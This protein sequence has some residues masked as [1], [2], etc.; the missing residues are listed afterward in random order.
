MFICRHTF[1]RGRRRRVFNSGWEVPTTLDV[2]EVFRELSTRPEGLTSF[3]ATERLR[4]Y[5]YNIVEERRE[6]AILDLLKR[7]WSPAAWLLEASIAISFILG[8]FAEGLIILTLLFVNALVGFRHARRSRKAVELLKSMLRP[9]ARVLRDGSWKIIDSREIVPGDVIL[10]NIGDTVPADAVVFEGL[11][12]V[13]ESAL[14]GESLPREKRVGDRVFAGSAVR[15]GMCKAVVVATG[16]K[17]YF[18][19]VVSLMK[20]ARPESHQEA[21]MLQVTKYMALLGLAVIAFMILYALSTG[22]V[23]DSLTILTISITIMMG[24]APVALPA[25]LSIMQAAEAVKLARGGVLVT[26]LDAL[27]DAGMVGIMCIDKTGTLTMNRLSV[28]GVKAVGDLTPEKVLELAYMAASENADNPVDRAIREYAES[29]GVRPTYR[30]LEY[31]PFSPELKRSEVVVEYCG[32]VLRIVMGAPQVVASLASHDEGVMTI[33]NLAVEEYSR[34]GFRCLG[35]A[36]GEGDLV[37]AGLIAMADPLRPESPSLI[38]RLKDLGLK[39]IMLTGDFK[40]IAVEVA[41]RVGLGDRVYSVG[42]LKVD[43]GTK[44][45][46]VNVDAIA[47]VYP[48]D[49]YYIVKKLQEMGHLVGMTGDGVNDAPALKQAE[50]GIAVSGATDV[51]KSAAGVVL[52]NP[53]LQGIIDVICAGRRV[54]KRVIAWMSNKIM[55][56]MQFTLLAALAFVWTRQPLLTLTGMSLLLLANDFATMSLAVDNVNPLEKP[57][58]L[59]VAR[60]VA[61]S[62]I[63]SLWLLIF[64]A[65]AIYIG[66]HILGYDTGK[67]QTL[68][69]LILV[70][71]SQFRVIITRETGPFYKT[72]PCKELLL[73]MMFVLIFFSL[74]GIYGILVTPLPANGV[75]FAL[76]Y[77][78]ATTLSADP[79]KLIAFKALKIG[80]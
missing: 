67:L 49:K 12:E 11:I 6:K 37:I 16:S 10:L 39:V 13:D 25:V 60:L 58:R 3:E 57:V 61:A 63:V 55:K 73:S 33:Y 70:F 62:T 43:S 35:V 48:G 20:M 56:T 69:M 71:S 50:L 22:L 64:G 79:V 34:R 65:L 28:I 54:A 38:R 76:I 72:K 75:V 44:D 2:G 51:A 14:T 1:S 5:G 31:R 27:E 77:S 52:V 41:R 47:E 30:L 8:R 19:K 24:A 21:M 45:I 74:L 53:G 36:F 7:F 26:R 17:T 18:G 80:L 9:S 59:S 66:E 4:L 42:E 32:K 46:I 40:L 15:N 78:A 68:T 23:N 29:K